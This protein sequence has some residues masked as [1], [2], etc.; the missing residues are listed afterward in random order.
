LRSINESDRLD[1]E[2]ITTGSAM[3]DRY[4]NGSNYQSLFIKKS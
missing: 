2:L 1:L 3:P 4:G